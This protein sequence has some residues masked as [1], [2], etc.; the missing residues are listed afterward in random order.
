M[1]RLEGIIRDAPDASEGSPEA[2]AP[3]H[4]RFQYREI[5]V[6][7]VAPTNRPNEYT[8]GLSYDGEGKRSSR[9]SR[10]WDRRVYL[11]SMMAPARRR[12]FFRRKGRSNVRPVAI[13]DV[14][15]YRVSTAGAVPTVMGMIIAR[16]KVYKRNDRRD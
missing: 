2:R 12:A 16:I 9:D 7:K 5:G 6:L 13:P 4:F 10:R 3:P 15:E 11:A 8:P 1:K 14:F